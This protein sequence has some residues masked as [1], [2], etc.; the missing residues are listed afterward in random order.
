MMLPACRRTHPSLNALDGFFDRLAPDSIRGVCHLR[1][2]IRKIYNCNFCHRRLH[3]IEDLIK[4]L[5]NFPAINDF[6]ALLAFQAWNIF[7]N[8]DTMFKFRNMCCKPFFHISFA[9]K[10]SHLTDSSF[11]FLNQ[12]PIFLG[13]EDMPL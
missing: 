2:L 9:I 7:D 5:H 10:A 4:L 6:P 8:Y 12:I 3:L 11:L 13:L 1:N